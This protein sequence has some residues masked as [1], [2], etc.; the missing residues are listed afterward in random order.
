M[1]LPGGRAD[2]SFSADISFSPSDDKTLFIVWGLVGFC[3]FKNLLSSSDLRWQLVHWSPN[4]CILEGRVCTKWEVEIRHSDSQCGLV[5]K[6]V[7]TVIARLLKSCVPSV[8]N[9]GLF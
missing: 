5:R 2:C 3:A 4:L 6:V 9:V 1:K 8:S 7:G